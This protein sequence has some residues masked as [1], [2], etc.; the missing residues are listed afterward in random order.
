MRGYRGASDMVEPL[1]HLHPASGTG[2]VGGGDQAVVPAA[3]NNDIGPLHRSAKVAL[4][5]TG[6]AHPRL[7]RI[8]TGFPKRPPLPQQVPALVEFNFHGAQALVLFGFVDL[9][10]LQLGTQLLLLGDQLVDLSEN[11]LVLSHR[12]RLRLLR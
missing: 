8:A 5:L 6:W 10:V 1:E 4:D 12:S 11:V 2:Q 9:M 3:D 7:P